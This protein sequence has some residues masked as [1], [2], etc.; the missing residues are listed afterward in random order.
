M[1]LHKSVVFDSRV[2]R[3]A[4]ALAADGHDVTVVHLA[5]ADVPDAVRSEGYRVVSALPQRLRERRLP[6][7]AHRLLFMRRFVGAIRALQPDAVHAHDAAMLAPGLVGARIVGARL[8]Y[9]SH[10][11]ATG[12]AYRERAWARFVWAL[13][14]L[15]VP[16][17]DAVV[18]VSDGIAARLQELYG[19]TE[20]PTVVRNLP[21][22]RPPNGPVHLRRRLGLPDDTPLVLHQGAAARGRGC[23]ALVRAMEHLPEAHLLFLGDD[24]PTYENR[25]DAVAVESG[26]SRRVHR[27]PGVPLEELLSYTAEADVGVSLLEDTCENHR[28]ALPNKVFEYMAAGVPV[29]V[30]DLPE[31]AALV[32]A[33]GGGL[34]APDPSPRPLGAAIRAALDMDAVSTSRLTWERERGRLLAV[35]ERLSGRRAAMA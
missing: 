9:D 22:L 10:E 33:H 24:D 28:L 30:S 13:E 6:F 29:V 27:L 17:C 11:L 4:K 15:V 35:Y 31:V 25:L 1:L 21:D 5:P 26:V 2:R 16:R 8:V 3:E 12:V 23:E 19:L 20:R 34:V 32:R 7:A 18:T 14:R